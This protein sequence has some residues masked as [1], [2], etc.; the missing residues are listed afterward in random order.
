MPL[1]YVNY[2][3]G[4]FTQEAINKLAFQ[5]TN[6]GE[7]AEKI[8]KTPYLFSTTWV[9]FRPYSSELVFHGGKSGG[10]KV[11]SLEVNVFEGGLDYAAKKEFYKNVT[12]AI[13][14]ATGLSKDQRR[15][16]YILVRDVPDIN[17]GFYGNIIAINDLLVA[18]KD[19][20]P[21]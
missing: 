17:W 13:A 15:P 14:E 1:M 20:K 12:E 2:P 4:T 8:P 7:D 21:I 19:E 10:T 11:I 18:S 6:F 5:L 9:Y 3:E 16:V